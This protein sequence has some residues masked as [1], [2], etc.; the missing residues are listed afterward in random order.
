[1][2][3]GYNCTCFAYGQTGTG[4]THTMSGDVVDRMG[5]TSPDAGIIPRM[6]TLL[7]TYL[8]RIPNSQHAIKCSFIELYNEELRDL[9]SEDDSTKLK[10]FEHGDFGTV[11]Q[12]TDE[13]YIHSAADGIKLLL[14][15]NSKRQ[16]AATKCNDRSSRSHT[17]FTITA[18]LKP[19]NN[20]S[21]KDV[22]TLGK[23]NLVDLAGSENIKNSGAS[24]KRAAEA[25]K[26]NKSLLTL[27][28]VINALVDH[29]QHIPYRQSNLTRL[30]QDSLGGRTKTCIIATISPVQTSLQ[31]TLSTL[32]YA[33]RAKSIKN[34]PQLN[35]P[36]DAK[37]VLSQIA[38]EAADMRKELAA[39]RSK[40]GVWMASD[41]YE[42]MK[43]RNESRAIVLEEQKARIKVLEANKRSVDQELYKLGDSYT[44]MESKF[45]EEVTALQSSLQV[46]IHDVD[47]LHDSNGRKSELQSVNQALWDATQ[48]LVEEATVQLLDAYR[49]FDGDHDEMLS[50]LL[51]A[52]DKYKKESLQQVGKCEAA[53]EEQ[54]QVLDGATQDL[55]DQVAGAWDSLRDALLGM[56]KVQDSGRTR[57]ADALDRSTKAVQT[58]STEIQS[59][60]EAWGSRVCMTKISERWNNTNPRADGGLDPL[61]SKGAPRGVRDRCSGYSL[62]PC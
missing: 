35:T 45:E 51:S 28:Q 43:T 46:M 41:A 1:M 57:T 39:A 49:E 56:Q 12:G 42:E 32:D 54:Q 6:F 30:L 31:E 2:L 21:S 14:K 33:S 10:I 23:L 38:R 44:A 18:Y 61:M 8:S 50:A 34:Q 37:L 48:S 59:A 16:V 15:G 27:G 25:G 17:V 13:R 3:K 47:Q 60:A 53:F 26:I 24:D 4:K 5:F 11:V 19:E 40:D 22:I 29:S 58:S 52:V 20:D 36:L 55:D 62:P 7:F 9:L